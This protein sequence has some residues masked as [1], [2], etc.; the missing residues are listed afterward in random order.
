MMK[1]I[2]RKIALLFCVVLLFNSFAP[3]TRAQNKTKPAKNKRYNV[4]FIASDHLRPDIQAYGNSLI[5]TPSIDRL[6]ARG[7]RFNRAYAQYPLCNPSRTAL[8]TGRYPTQ[9]KIYNSNDYFRRKFPGWVTL[10]QYF[11]NNG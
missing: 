5:Q 3:L 1:L 7:T 8:L 9:T 4:L 2:S 11:K 10:P 6:A